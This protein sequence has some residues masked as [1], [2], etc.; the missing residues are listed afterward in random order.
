MIFNLQYLIYASLAVPLSWLTIAIFVFLPRF[1]IDQGIITFA[2]LG[3]LALVYRVLDAVLDVFIGRYLEGHKSKVITPFFRIA[4]VAPLLGLFIFIVF[5]PAITGY[6]YLPQNVTLIVATILLVVAVTT[7]QI[8]Y[9]SVVPDLVHDYVERSRLLGYRAVGLLIGSFL[10]SAT[11]FYLGY[12]GFDERSAWLI[13]GVTLALLF[14]ISACLIFYSLKVT[15]KPMEQNIPLQK[16]LPRIKELLIEAPVYNLIIAYIFTSIGSA[17]PAALILFYIQYVLGS[18]NGALFVGMYLLVAILS[19]PL[20]NFVSKKFEKNNSWILGILLNAGALFYIYTLERGD[21][22][23]YGIAVV[24]SAIGYGA[25]LLFP[26]SMQADLIDYDEHKNGVRRQAEIAALCLFVKKTFA[27]I[28]LAGTFFLLGY[29]PGADVQ[30]STAK[31]IEI[32]RILYALVPAVCSMMA[33][34]WISRYRLNKGDLRI[35]QE[36]LASSG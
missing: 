36:N 33:I 12:L 20:W 31:S 29:T 35:I 18:T 34:F 10:A 14:I 26:A 28:C 22:F 27:A 9:D 13:I 16:L 7:V 19:L 24:L 1:Y 23:Q 32:L 11:P 6:L 2:G 25:T 15:S 30:F 5:Y 4:V 3:V 21:E 8:S 17:L